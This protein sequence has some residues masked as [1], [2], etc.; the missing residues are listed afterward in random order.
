MGGKKSIIAILF[1]IIFISITTYLTTFKV[2]ENETVILTQFGRVTNT[3]TKPGLHFKFPAPIQNTLSF[4]RKLNVLESVPTE[5]LTRDKK[6]LVINNYG[7]WRIKNPLKFYK[8]VKNLKGALIHL[9][10]IIYSQMRNEVGLYSFAEIITSKREEISASL[11]NK[12]GKECNAIGVE[13]VD[14]RLKWI[15][16]PYQ[17]LEAIY[18][19]MIAERKKIATKYRSEGEEEAM[20]IKSETEKEKTIILA[21]SYKKA[22]ALKGEGEA[23]AMDNYSKI[24][25][26]DTGF[27]SFIR[28]MEIYTDIIKKDT[29]MILSTDSPLLKHLNP[30]RK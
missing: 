15:S 29:T 10:D 25:K 9:E 7:V 19:R 5:I 3:I 30:P 11:T 16:F 27:Y 22:E 18:K 12:V 6:N 2:E 8:T 4:S 17:N 21:K 28:S 23:L 1:A 20:K 13:I 14:I 26:K 24:I